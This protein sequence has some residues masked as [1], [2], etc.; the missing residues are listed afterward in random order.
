MTT[1]DQNSVLVLIDTTPEGS[2]AASSAELLGAAA[3]LGTPV[4]LL[5]LAAEPAQAGSADPAQA[6]RAVQAAQALGA[7]GAAQVLTATVD[8]DRLTGP[9][10]DAL[11][12]AVDL[13]SPLAVLAAHSV[14]GREAAARLAARRQLA[15]LTDVVGVGRDAE[16]I[17]TDHSAFGGAFLGQGA[18]TTGTPVITLRQGTVE[19]RAGGA[20]GEVQELTFQDSGAA[21]ASITAREAAQG[22]S[23]RPALRGAKTVVSGGR[24]LGSEDGFE[25]VGR[26]ADALGAAV[27]ASRAAVDA[28]YVPSNTQVGQ[29]GVTISPQLYVALGISGA[30]Q[31]LAGMQTAKNIV[32]INKDADA[33]IFSV[34]DFGVVGDVFTVVPALIEALETRRKA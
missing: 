19:A 26:L 25:L 14:A 10:V 34:A 21:A 12:V 17:V 30:V 3:Q 7:A 24:G 11:A 6:D 4:A 5:P 2:P 9:V 31:H 18:A 22:N 29:T 15:L 16:G 13:V 32:A 27:G 1:F 23:E 28:G 20:A 8:A 33:P